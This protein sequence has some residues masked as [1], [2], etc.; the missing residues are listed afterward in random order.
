MK[1]SHRRSVAV[2]LA[3]AVVIASAASMSRPVYAETTLERL[4]KAKE[5]KEKTEDAKEDT[6]NR[7]DSLEITQNSLLGQL[8]T[9]NDELAQISTNLEGIEADITAKESEIAQTEAELEEAIRV[10][11]EQYVNM[12]L[13]I[14]AMYEQGGTDSYIGILFS[15]ESFSEFLNKSDYIDR[16]QAYDRKMLQN[17]QDT[18]KYVAE[19]KVQ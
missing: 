17:F 11:D 5:E 19:T 7:K 16:V 3:A 9:L 18:C 8:S 10:Q 14:K 13:R 2:L 4:Q 12:K 15:S 6:E 1:V